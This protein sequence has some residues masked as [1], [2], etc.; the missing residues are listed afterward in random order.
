MSGLW[1]GV[2]LSIKARYNYLLVTDKENRFDGYMVAHDWPIKHYDEPIN[3][4]QAVVN[5][6]EEEGIDIDYSDKDANMDVLIDVRIIS[7][8]WNVLDMH[9][10][11]YGGVQN[12]D[13]SYLDYEYDI[14][15]QVAQDD[16]ARFDQAAGGN[17]EVWNP[18]K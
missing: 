18:P 1:V 14:E 8:R 15:E 9:R 17:T 3:I 7:P 5:Y 11:V 2:I 10:K 6:V 4:P 12:M 16:A 13:A